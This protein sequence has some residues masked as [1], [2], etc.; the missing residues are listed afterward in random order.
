ML[1]ISFSAQKTLAS[2]VRKLS[3]KPLTS[4]FMRLEIS[5]IGLSKNIDRQT[6]WREALYSDILNSMTIYIFGIRV[7]RIYYYSSLKDIYLYR[8]NK[9]FIQTLNEM[10]E[11][12]VIDPIEESSKIL[13][14]GCN[15]GGVLK[16]LNEEFG[17]E[18]HG[19]DI[20]D[21]AIREGKSFFRDNEKFNL[22]T[23]DALNHEFLDNYEDNYFTHV[24]CVAHLVHVPNGEDKRKYIEQLKRVGSNVVF[25]E[26]ISSKGDP[27]RKNKYFFEDYVSSYSFTE[28]KVLD[29][30]FSKKDLDCML[31]NKRIKKVGFFYY[32]KQ[33]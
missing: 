1:L 16:S 25:F 23:A 15:I 20:S 11:D 30:V 4:N 14:G 22:F 33:I 31:S 28:Y 5:K 10:I 2:I 18:V 27:P 7:L 6:Y 21:K 24:F 3:T 19:F 26:R 8:S 29:K 13:E 9:Q 17:C 32:K 12:E